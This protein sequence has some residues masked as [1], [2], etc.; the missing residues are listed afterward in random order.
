MTPRF[1]GIV[2][3]A[4]SALAA[5]GV[6]LFQ[7]RS[8]A[9]PTTV[10]GYGHVLLWPLGAM[11]GLI[12]LIQSN[13][14]GS[15]PV[16]RAVAFLPVIGIGLGLVAVL[17]EAAGVSPTDNILLHISRLIMIFG[18]V[19]VGI[20]TIAAKAWPGWRRFVPLV[21]IL[22]MVLPFATGIV[23][24][25]HVLGQAIASGVWVLLGFVVATA[26]GRSAAE[27]LAAA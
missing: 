26:E 9:P 24:V 13:G 18:M 19:L 14:V 27:Q 12:G 10:I 15:N 5:A 22:V 16:V 7:F 1:L 8:G 20:L 4:A 23:D 2:C 17:T 11:A 3:M 25:D 6:L 21:I